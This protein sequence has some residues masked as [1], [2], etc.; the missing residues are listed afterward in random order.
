MTTAGATERKHLSNDAVALA[1]HTDESSVCEDVL[2]GFES[3]LKGAGLI[4]WGLN[5]CNVGK[6]N[7]FSIKWYSGISILLS[8]SPVYIYM[9]LVGFVQFLIKYAEAI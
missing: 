8:R 2:P 4:T 7:C 6:D 9:A 3:T 1:R 5:R